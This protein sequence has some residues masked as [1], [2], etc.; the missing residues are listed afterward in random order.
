MQ[1]QRSM[2]GASISLETHKTICY[3]AASNPRSWEAGLLLEVL[4][5]LLPSVSLFLFS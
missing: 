1:S 5:C 4:S 3:S 2:N